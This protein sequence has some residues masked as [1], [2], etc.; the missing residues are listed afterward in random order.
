MVRIARVYA[1]QRATNSALRPP[2]VAEALLVRASTSRLVSSTRVLTL[3][4]SSASTSMLRS[5]SAS[6]RTLPSVAAVVL[7]L[8][9]TLSWPRLS[10]ASFSVSSSSYSPC[11]E[12]PDVVMPCAG[13]S[14]ASPTA[15]ASAPSSTS[16]LT[17]AT[18]ALASASLAPAALSMAACAAAPTS[19][20]RFRRSASVA[21][22]S[23]SSSS[24]PPSS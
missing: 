9:P 16:S 8:F 19:S 7:V 20:A 3:P 11:R 24:P 13:V 6:T 10:G 4:T 14:V 22:T 15:Y 1:P 17:R 5:R 12:V 18:A 23:A 21:A 2:V